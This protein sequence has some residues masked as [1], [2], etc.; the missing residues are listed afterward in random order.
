MKQI[1]QQNNNDFEKLIH[2]V[3]QTHRLSQENTIKAVNF[4]LTVRNL[5]VGCYIVEY[6]QKGKDRAQYGTRLLEEMA[7]Q[8]KILGIERMRS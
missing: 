5:L 2:S 6:E 1:E 8:K 4:N 3:Y 7:K